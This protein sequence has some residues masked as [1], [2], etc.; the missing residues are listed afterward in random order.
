MKNRVQ[1]IIVSTLVLIL[2]VAGIFIFYLLNQ[3]KSA[4][5]PTIEELL[6]YSLDIP[7]I[8]TNLNS[9]QIIRIAFKIQT[10]SE[11]AK[12][13]LENRTFQVNNLI[14][15]QLSGMDAD[16]LSGTEGKIKLEDELK[17]Q[18]NEIMTNGQVD[19]VYI[20]SIIMQ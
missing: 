9:S 4:E 13:E 15:K 5:E 17:S 3:N 6:E 14:I 18:I 10:N 19:Q 12:S 8:T 16:E 11:D 2:I 7:E 20:T 1:I